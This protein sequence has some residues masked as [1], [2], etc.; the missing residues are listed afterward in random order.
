M[1]RTI[2]TILT[3]VLALACSRIE[4][5]PA[6]GVPDEVEVSFNI[7]MAEPVCKS[8]LG[9]GEKFIRD[10]NILAYE[11]G[12]L[13]ESCHSTSYG[14]ISLK[15]TKGRDYDLYALA[16][17]G[18]AVTPE[19]EGELLAMEL[20]MKQISDLGQGF[21]MVWKGHLD[22]SDIPS[23][24]TIRLRRLVARI[25]L[26]FSSDALK[27]LRVTSVRLMQAASVI[28]PF[29]ES[30]SAA[31]K[32][33]TFDGDFSSTADI[34]VVNSGG[35]I[36]F[37]TAENLQGTLLPGNGDPWAKVPS[38][39]GD[40][41]SQ[42]TYLEVSC[43]FSEGADY[44]GDVIYRLYLGDDNCT[45]FDV[46][47][48][49]DMAITIFAT[50]SGL[51]RVSWKIENNSIPSREP[52]DPY[53][54]WV[55]GG[56]VLYKAQ[57]GI[58]L[59]SKGYPVRNI[60][61][62]SSSSS[63]AKVALI[64]EDERYA[65]IKVSG[66]HEGAARLNIYGDSGTLLSQIPVSV[67]TPTIKPSSG[68][69]TLGTDGRARQVS[70]RFHDVSGNVMS[71]DDF[72]SELYDLWLK[73]SYKLAKGNEATFC[74][75]S[76]SGR[77]DAYGYPVLDVWLYRNY[78]GRG[79]H[80]VI[81]SATEDGLVATTPSTP[82]SMSATADLDFEE[83]GS[84]HLPHIGD[85]QDWSLFRTSGLNDLLN[86][87]RT[88][89]F[90]FRYD[91]ELADADI[92][93]ISVNGY[94]V[95][96]MGETG[97]NEAMDFS[98][99]QIGSTRYIKASLNDTAPDG[100]IRNHSCGR[101]IISISSRLADGSMFTEEYGYVNVYVHT[102]IGG[103]RTPLAGTMSYDDKT[104]WGYAAGADWATD[105]ARCVMMKNLDSRQA[106]DRAHQWLV[107]NKSGEAGKHEA[108]WIRND[109]YEHGIGR[110]LYSVTFQ[111]A[112]NGTGY[113][114]QEAA[115][116]RYRIDEPAF[117][118]RELRYGN[119]SL[120]GIMDPY[121]YFPIGSETPHESLVDEDGQGFLVIHHL[122]SIAPSTGGWLRS[123]ETDIP[124]SDTLL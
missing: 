115:L 31:R 23:T 62:V 93:S 96:H 50:E 114:T 85:I 33:E 119:N 43:R 77:N 15:L 27:G 102:A 10:I 70:F 89:D 56:S 74:R 124:E 41:A 45:N 24:V 3:S 81:T 87:S 25:G 4:P 91:G 37:Y 68:R 18:R 6:P 28:R 12:R 2:L 32:G 123:D 95:N 69:I 75:F 72:D 104:A 86:V 22:G 20:R 38:N 66:Y 35:I 64:S 65:T 29:S 44:I 67:R 82:Y 11:N 73:P 26:K 54:E 5:M 7:T 106:S 98:M 71:R 108:V 59:Y 92:S 118:I 40:A 1:K 55:E 103:I 9:S 53:F 121:F 49:V 17:A 116:A 120:L 101:H 52:E 19:S 61:G 63:A 21:P 113:A 109:G 42:A 48:N 57:S 30:G 8:S 16:N 14:N 58:I 84:F 99:V 111:K 112:Y 47:G 110:K 76:D 51:D 97:R 94:A 60:T 83:N 90:L 46:H 122:K 13:A 79:E 117:T 39:I 36:H 100:A 105:K 88:D 78:N 80:Y 34:D 107:Y